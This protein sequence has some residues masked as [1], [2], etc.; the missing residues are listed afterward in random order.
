M[1]I[2]MPAYLQA[3]SLD[4]PVKTARRR[5]HD[6]Q[7]YRN[8]RLLT[9]RFPRFSREKRDFAPPPNRQAAAGGFSLPAVLAGGFG[10]R[11]RP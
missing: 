3:F 8:H 10:G 6:Y 9:T 11:N 5:N 7:S 4:F 1:A 2:K